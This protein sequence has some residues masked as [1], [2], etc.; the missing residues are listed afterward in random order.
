MPRVYAGSPPP[1]VVSV[2]RRSSPVAWTLWSRRPC[3]RVV[4]GGWQLEVDADAGPCHGWQWRRSGAKARV[5][6]GL[7]LRARHRRRM[8][9]T[10]STS[11][12]QIRSILAAP[13]TLVKS[14]HHNYASPARWSLVFE[15]EQD[16]LDDGAEPRSNLRHRAS[17]AQ[18]NVSHL[19]SQYEAAT[20]GSGLGS[21]Q[22]RYGVNYRKLP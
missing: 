18:T 10:L 5:R 17:R 6:V 12:D 2:G 7:Q 11:P 8:V 9:I 3:T 13:S 4:R 20:L 1:S 19:W 14:K 15:S 22:L 16:W 21:D